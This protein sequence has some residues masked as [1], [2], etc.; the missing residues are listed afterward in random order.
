MEG[1]RGNLKIKC[2]VTGG[3]L[4]SMRWGDRRVMRSLGKKFHQEIL[5]QRGRIS[6]ETARS[7]E[8][9]CRVSAG[10]SIRKEKDAKAKGYATHLRD[11]PNG[12]RF[13]K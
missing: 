1:E 5:I 11:L 10:E 4:I 9:E 13:K 8:L 2:K 12:K 6:R 7:R 3:K